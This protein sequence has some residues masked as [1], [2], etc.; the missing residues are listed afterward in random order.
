MFFKMS[1]YGRTNLVP[2]PIQLV[3][4]IR[5]WDRVDTPMVGKEVT[6]AYFTDD[7]YRLNLYLQ[8]YRISVIF[9]NK[10]SKS[11]LDTRNLNLLLVSMWDRAALPGCTLYQVHI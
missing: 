6:V 2:V 1:W 4:Q 3:L 7:K 9:K 8:L 5:I 10:V 11:Y